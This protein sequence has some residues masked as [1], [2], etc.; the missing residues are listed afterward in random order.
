MF[1][2]KNMGEMRNAFRISSQVK[3]TLEDQMG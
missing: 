1:N 3:G 2:K